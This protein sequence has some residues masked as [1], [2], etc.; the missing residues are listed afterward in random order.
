[1]RRWSQDECVRLLCSFFFQAEDGIRVGAVTGVQTCALPIYHRVQ[2][3][4]YHYRVW[5]KKE[6][7]S[8]SA[9]SLGIFF[10][11]DNAQ[12]RWVFK[13]DDPKVLSEIDSVFVTL[14]PPGKNFSE[15]KGDKFLYAYLRNQPNHP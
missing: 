8:Q 13:Y 9:K 6:G 10:S 14:E 11:D 1:M 7:P 5:G 3:A 2:D 4:G 12:K 15:P